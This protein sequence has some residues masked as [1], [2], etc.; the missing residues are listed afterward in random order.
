MK[1]TTKP[2]K[3][4]THIFHQICKLIPVGLVKDMAVKHDVS[5]KCRSFSAWSHVVALLF[6]QITHAVSLNDV[7]DVLRHRLPK[8]GAI[9]GAT[10]P[11]RNGFSHANRT[12]NSN[13][14]ESLFWQV[15]AHLQSQHPGF[16]PSSSYVKLPRK[17]KRLVHAV[18]SS[19]IA[20]VANCMDW[21]KHR[22]RKAA[23]KL[24]LR[25]NLQTFLPGFAVIEEASHHD[26]RRMGALCA[27]VQA[28][29][30]VIFDKAYVHFEHLFELAR[31]GV[32]WITRAKDNIAVKVIKRNR[33]TA[34]GII[35]DEEIELTGAKSS[36][37]YPVRM[38]RI[39][40][41]VEVNGEMVEM[42]FIT[43]NLEW[44]AR[45]VCDLYAAR[46][47]IE[48][49]FKQIKQTLKLSDFLGYSKHAIRWQIWAALL[50]YVLLRFQGWAAQ[51]A[52]SFTRLFAL[53]RGLLWER[54]NLSDLLR[55]YGT[56]SEPWR[57]CAQPEQ[58]YFPGF[59]R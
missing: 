2:T 9:R 13:M 30:I 52:H 31:R 58:T 7:C 50:L 53:V 19:T 27:G 38:R 54:F 24:H 51:W 59:A 25:L 20:L 42:V 29:E 8:L 48:V 35:A 32:F 56:A 34:E 39:R 1:K 36:R 37:L 12:R 33:N 10:A 47:A 41:L 15:L 43:N 21:A 26:S 3:H 4:H 18:D 16:G 22:R 11:S 14:M 6:S 40:A 46:W 17:I 23:A 45:S 28:G 44:V 55:D 5:G 57:M 49:F